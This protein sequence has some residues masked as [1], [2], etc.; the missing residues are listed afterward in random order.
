MCPQDCGLPGS[1]D[2]ADTA[3]DLIADDMSHWR[4]RCPVGTIVSHLKKFS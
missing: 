3:T 1:P 2:A 4:E